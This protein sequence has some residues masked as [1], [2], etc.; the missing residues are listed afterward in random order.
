MFKKQQCFIDRSKCILFLRQ[1]TAKQKHFI[2][3]T[4]FQI[5][6]TFQKIR[7]I[8]NYVREWRYMKNSRQT[9]YSLHFGIRINFTKYFIL[10]LGLFLMT[11]TLGKALALTLHFKLCNILHAF[12]SKENLFHHCRIQLCCIIV[13]TIQA[14]DFMWNKLTNEHYN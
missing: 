2:L 3:E 5:L 8:S 13:V 6:Y 10:L 9:K 1:I 11:F 7:F 14:F 12:G 4:L